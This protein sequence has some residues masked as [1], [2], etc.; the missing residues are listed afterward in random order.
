MPERN[1]GRITDGATFEALATT[2]VFFEDAQ[3]CLVDRKRWRPRLAV[4]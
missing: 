4:R 1:W 3:L 2:L